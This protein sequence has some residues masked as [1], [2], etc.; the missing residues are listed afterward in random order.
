MAAENS[1][2][3]HNKCLSH[4]LLCLEILLSISL[5]RFDIAFRIEIVKSFWRLS[6]ISKEAELIHNS[7]G[8]ALMKGVCAKEIEFA[9]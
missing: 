4:Q 9:N 1:N 3:L 6:R 5:K 7:W 8:C 2:A